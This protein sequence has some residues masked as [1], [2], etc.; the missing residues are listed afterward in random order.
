MTNNSR[1]IGL[2]TH[3]E[4]IA[5]AIAEDGRDGEVHYYGQIAN[6]ESIHLLLSLAEVRPS[7]TSITLLMKYCG[8]LSAGPVQPDCNDYLTPE[9]L[10]ALSPRYNPIF[11]SM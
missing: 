11:A 2:D 10:T 1:F 3:K 5:V 6:E 7:N 8:A 4:T 9:P